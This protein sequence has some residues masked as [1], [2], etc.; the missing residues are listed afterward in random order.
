MILYH[1]SLPD[2]TWAGFIENLAQAIPRLS[3]DMQTAY[4]M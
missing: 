2:I 3:G 1:A 4:L